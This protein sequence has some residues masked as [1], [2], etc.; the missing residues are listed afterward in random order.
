MPRGHV[1]LLIAAAVALATASYSLAGPGQ[2]DKSSTAR[3]LV[4]AGLHLNENGPCDRLYE[5]DAPGLPPMCTHGPDAAP[6]GIDVTVARDTAELA[7][8]TAGDAAVPCIG[9]GVS[10]PRVQSIYAVA[11]DRADRYDSVEPLIAGWAGQMDSALNQSAAKTGGERHIRFVTNADCSLSVAH[12][13][14]SPTGDDSINNTMT[15]LQNAGYKLS[16]RKYLVWTDTTGVYCGIA[17]VTTDDVSGSANRANTATGYAR[18]DTACWGGT[19]HLTELHELFHN[20]GA[21][22][23]SAPHSSGGYHCTD[24]SDVM[25]YQDSG[26]ATLTYPCPAIDEWLLDCGNDDYFHTAPAAE[27]YLATHWNTADSLFLHAGSPSGVTGTAALSLA[28]TMSPTTYSAVGQA[29]SYGY[30]VTNGG[31]LTLGPAQFTVS[32]TKVDAGA[33]FACGPAS[34]TLS[35][36]A[37]VTCSASHTITQAD[38]DTGSV[39]SSATASGGGATSASASVTVTAVPPPPQATITTTFSGSLSRKQSKRTYTLTVG[40]GATVNALQFSAGG[41]A[42]TTA[43]LTLRVL[44]PNGSAVAATTGPSVVQLT[45]APLASGTYTWEVSGSV[46]AS[47]T[48]R[49]TYTTP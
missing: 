29:V 24:E 38:L 36:G 32:D 23:L 8:T 17:T 45:T 46:S 26:T 22:Q 5:L 15:E 39:T 11:S 35:P 4:L 12:V 31:T 2:S 42:K 16:G 27:S 48:L 43:T 7:G 47:F 10:G 49:V 44:G 9:D 34:M 3:G 33:P 1:I 28:R 37:T 18:V 13:L 20:I 19:D 21:V 41:K 25:C 40:D 30:T 14:L 6:D